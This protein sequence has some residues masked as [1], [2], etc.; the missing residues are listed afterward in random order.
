MS[1]VV[2]KEGPKV[3]ILKRSGEGDEGKGNGS[4]AGSSQAKSS[5]GA[6]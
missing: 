5:H 2:G 4:C 6:G 3:C 1:G